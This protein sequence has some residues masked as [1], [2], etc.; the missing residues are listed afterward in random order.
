[1]NYNHPELK[2]DRNE[3]K[4]HNIAKRMVNRGDAETYFLEQENVRLL[5]NLVYLEKEK[6]FMTP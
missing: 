2:E 6:A 3:N 4:H 5:K 1:M